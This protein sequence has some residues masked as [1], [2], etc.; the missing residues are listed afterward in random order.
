MYFIFLNEEAEKFKHLS[1]NL[2][3]EACLKLTSGLAAYVVNS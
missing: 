1:K 2:V 3:L